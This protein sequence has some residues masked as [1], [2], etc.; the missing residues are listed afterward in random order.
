MPTPNEQ[1]LVVRAAQ[2]LLEAAPWDYKHR[3]YQYPEVGCVQ[4]R[5]AT[6][7]IR[8][9]PPPGSWPMVS[10]HYPAATLTQRGWAHEVA[11]K[12]ERM[13]RLA[14]GFPERPCPPN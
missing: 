1:T 14:A 7:Y 3:V 2:Y 12:L 10:L 5:Q 6:F 11:D 9:G 13:L 4:F 8:L